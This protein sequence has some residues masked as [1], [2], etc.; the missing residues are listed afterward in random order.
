MADIQKPAVFAWL[1]FIS[2]LPYILLEENKTDSSGENIIL[3]GHYF[4]PTLPYWYFFI[5]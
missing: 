4:T 3:H 5:F 2:S 1:L